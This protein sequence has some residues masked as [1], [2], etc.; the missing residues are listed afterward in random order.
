MVTNE[1]GFYRVSKICEILSIA[2]S[3]WWLWVKNGRAPKGFKISDGITVWPK[4]VIHKFL[5]EAPVGQPQKTKDFY[6]EKRQLEYA[7]VE[8]LARR[9]TPGTWVA[10]GR[11]IENADDKLP[12]ICF[13]ELADDPE[14]D[15]SN[16]EFIA[17]MNPTFVLKLIRRLREYEDTKN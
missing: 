14:Q 6:K 11:Q 12:D 16:A 8:R 15:K 2:K 7:H 1:I 17:A 4:D 9:A 13:C 10:V 3:T 5:K